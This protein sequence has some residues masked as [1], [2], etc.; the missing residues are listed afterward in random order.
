[1]YAIRSYYGTDGVQVSNEAIQGARQVIEKSYG[2][3]YLPS[4]PRSY[5]SKARNAQEAHEA[6]R[7]T[8]L[9][10]RPRDI[11]RHL[12]ADERRLYELIWIRMLASQMESARP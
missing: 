10:R 9:A 2:P 8:D 12:D 5:K 11:A 6:I 4:S 1:M 7:P 3:Q